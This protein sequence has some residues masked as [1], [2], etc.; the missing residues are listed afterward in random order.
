LSESQC[1]R[2]LR[3]LERAKVIEQYIAIINLVAVDLPIYGVIEIRLDDP[4]KSNME[5]FER[6]MDKMPSIKDCWYT[7]GDANYLLAASA[8]DPPAYERVLDELTT[9][10]RVSIVRS[11]LIL[12]NVK[13]TS[14]AGRSRRNPGPADV[15]GPRSRKRLDDFD[16]RILAILST[17]ARISNAELARRIGLSPAPCLRRVQALET[18][19]IIQSYVARVDTA[20]LNLVI[21]VV[22]IRFHYEN[23]QLRALFEQSLL[24]IPEIRHLSRTNGESDYLVVVEAPSLTALE[25]LLVDSL[26]SHSG[27]K[28]LQSAIRLRN[29]F[30]TSKLVGVI[31]VP[32]AS[33]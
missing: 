28:G 14:R 25:R 5:M 12:R 3:A 33:D 17:D 18:A 31:L 29:C 1:S 30:R 24:K 26:L 23:R 8:P 19:G 7:S 21:A 2:R 20:A 27:V 9:I 13:P 16:R 10:N 6:A 22:R 15:T 4:T 32:G 11:L